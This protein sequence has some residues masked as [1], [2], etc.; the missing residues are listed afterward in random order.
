MQRINLVDK[1]FTV[2]TIFQQNSLLLVAEQ[3]SIERTHHMF[4]FLP[5]AAEHPDWFCCLP[6]RENLL[7]VDVCQGPCQKSHI[8]LPGNRTACLDG[9][10][11]CF[12]NFHVSFLSGSPTFHFI[13]QWIGFIL[14][15]MHTS[16]CYLFSWWLPFWLGW[17]EPQSKLQQIPLMVKDIEHKIFIGQ[18]Y[19]FVKDSFYYF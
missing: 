2:S 14:A 11:C 15:H 3:N 4:T 19:I 5:C 8:T 12:Q 18:F 1:I 16:A 17:M 7:Q 10:F 9:A 6:T 13:Q